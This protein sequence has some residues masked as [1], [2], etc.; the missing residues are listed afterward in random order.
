MST[1]GPTGG[2]SV[3]GHA[4]GLYAL[5]FSHDGKILATGGVAG[6]LRGNG[7]DKSIKIWN[8]EDGRELA[9]L[10]GH[11][12]GIYSLTFAPDGKSLVAADYDGSMRHWNLDKGQV[13][14]TLSLIKRGDRIVGTPVEPWAITPDLKSWAVGTGKSVLW[15]DIADFTGTEN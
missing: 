14:A 12:K 11:D 2:K 9:R 13:K 4:E 6:G 7:N 5:A 1:D 8:V 10:V 3:E 15:L